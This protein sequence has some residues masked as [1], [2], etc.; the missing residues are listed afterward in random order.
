VV[1]GERVFGMTS[2]FDG[3]NGASR[4]VG[5]VGWIFGAL[6]L[7]GGTVLAAVL[8]PRPLEAVT[9]QIEAAPVLSL[10]LGVVSVPVAVVLMIVLAVSIIGSP[11]ILLI[12]PAYVALLLFGAVVVSFLAGRRLL[13]ATGRY[14]GGNALAAVAGALLV[15][16]VYLIPFVG[17]FLFATLAFFGL[18]AT[19]LALFTRR[20]S[21]GSG[22]SYE[23]YVR[24]RGG[25]IQP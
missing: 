6:A 15:A 4:V 1:N 19:L 11:L 25:E 13:F 17:H 14:H 22:P 10:V 7:V 12:I 8:M 23:A 20:R 9:R 16:A 18:G 24:D 3:A 5:F 2:D 21:R